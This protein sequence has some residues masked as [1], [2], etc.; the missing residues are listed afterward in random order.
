[1]L[2]AS[3]VAALALLVGFGGEVTA[4]PNPAS[5]VPFSQLAEAERWEQSAK[6]DGQWWTYLGRP[7]SS[8]AELH[9]FPNV[10]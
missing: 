4:Q 2:A 3:S 10:P 8:L 1:M 5:R 9:A 7:R 6:F